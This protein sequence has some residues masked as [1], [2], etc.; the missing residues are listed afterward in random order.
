MNFR[1]RRMVF[2]YLTDRL[3]LRL[4]HQVMA[5]DV[6]DHVARQEYIAVHNIQIAEPAFRKRIPT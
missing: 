6:S 1:P 4:S 3:H 5:G 2:Y